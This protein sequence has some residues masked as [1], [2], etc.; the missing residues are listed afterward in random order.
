MVTRIL[1]V[2]FPVLVMVL[3][4]HPVDRANPEPYTPADTFANRRVDNRHAA[5]RVL[6]HA[7]DEARDDWVPLLEAFLVTPI[8]FRV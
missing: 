2:Q 1:L 7:R 3:F 5:A 4:N 8:P 6:L